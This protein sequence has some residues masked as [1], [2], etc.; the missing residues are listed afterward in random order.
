MRCIH[1][2][3]EASWLVRFYPGALE[4][5]SWHNQKKAMFFPEF[6]NQSIGKE[7]LLVFLFVAVPD[8][9]LAIC[10]N[11]ISIDRPVQQDP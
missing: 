4:V 7:N 3:S 1:R 11:K 9:V 8:S 10:S 6:D 5:R 2:A